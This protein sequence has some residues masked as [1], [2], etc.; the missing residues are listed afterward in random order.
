M[1]AHAVM[2]ELDALGDRHRAESAA[3][4]FKTGPGQYGEG[5]EFI[6]V[7]V[8]QQRMV[9]R[10]HRDLPVSELD[11]LIASPIHEH[12]LTAVLI[13]ADQMTRSTRHGDDATAARIVDWYLAAARRG[14]VNNWDIVD[15]SAA[16]I[17]GQWLCDR[18]RDLLTELAGVDDLWL[19]RIAMVATHAFIRAGDASTTLE[20]AVRYLAYRED[21]LQ[22][23]T[24]W[25][26][27]E[28]GKRVDPALL[29]AFLDAHAA[30]MPAT[31]LGY[32]IEHLPAE[33]RRHYRTADHRRFTGA[34]HTAGSPVRSTPSVCGD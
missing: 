10:T 24:G 6:G 1:T 14:R 15:A 26:L 20:L 7:P 8:P 34:F 29:V 5:D 25:M 32:A 27:R 19:R 22:K 17:V 28:V 16:P 21:L 18:P 13:A 23:A 31:M 2:N 33:T 30:G 12:R 11:R 4:F 3:G 9:A